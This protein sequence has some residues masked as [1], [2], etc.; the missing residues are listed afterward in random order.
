MSDETTDAAGETPAAV[1][2]EPDAAAATPAEPTPPK[3]PT[4]PALGWLW[5]LFS[6]SVLGWIIA[7]CF[8]VQGVGDPYSVSTM[9]LITVGVTALVFILTTVGAFF[10]AITLHGIHWLHRHRDEL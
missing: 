9:G 1:T 5:A 4:N 3:A 7:G 8:F 6:F 2:T 10:A